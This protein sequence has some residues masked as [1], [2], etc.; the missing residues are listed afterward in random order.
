MTKML[1]WKISF[2][3]HVHGQ[4]HE[5]P[6]YSWGLNTIVMYIYTHDKN[7]HVP[8][9]IRKHI[10]SSLIYRRKISFL[11]YITKQ[12]IRYI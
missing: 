7:V 10:F 2:Y 5:F 8:E 1:F 11:E 4:N 12:Y 3:V 9:D 6:E